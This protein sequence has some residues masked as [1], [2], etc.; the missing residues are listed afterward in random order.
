MCA[1]AESMVL[2]SAPGFLG[3]VVLMAWSIRNPVESS[4]PSFPNSSASAESEAVLAPGIFW[5]RCSTYESQPVT[6]AEP[7]EDRV[8]EID[9]FLEG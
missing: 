7:E 6:E 2:R 5:R 3:T 1:N 9:C 8:R 4:V